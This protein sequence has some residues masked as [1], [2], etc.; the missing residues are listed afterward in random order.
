MKLMKIVAIASVM[1]VALAG[2]GTDSGDYDHKGQKHG[3]HG[4]SSTGTETTKLRMV[5][6]QNRNL[7]S[8]APRYRGNRERGKYL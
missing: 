6:T 1:T 2:C 5:N 3:D 4:V 8:N 7:E